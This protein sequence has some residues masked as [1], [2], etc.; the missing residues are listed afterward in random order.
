MGTRDCRPI[1]SK[2][3]ATVPPFGEWRTALPS[4]LTR[5]WITPR[6]SP[7]TGDLAASGSDTIVTLLRARP[8]AS[9]RPTASAGQRDEV[10]AVL[11]LAGLPAHRLNDRQEMAGG[12]GDIAGIVGIV[13]AQRPVDCVDDPLGA[14]R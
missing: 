4:R 10:D 5:I 3:I 12:R 14:L 2:V 9:S 13:A 8:F 7:W 1:A 6:A 11:V